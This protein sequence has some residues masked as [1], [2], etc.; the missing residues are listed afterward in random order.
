MGT[1]IKHPVPDRVTPSFVIFDIRALWCSGARTSKITNDGLTQSG[2]GCFTY[3]TTVGVKGLRPQRE[4][5]TR[6][7]IDF[8]LALRNTLV[9]PSVAL[10]RSD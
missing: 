4:R 9:C 2:T 8:P 6:D 10:V 5:S 7:L 1:A 3:M